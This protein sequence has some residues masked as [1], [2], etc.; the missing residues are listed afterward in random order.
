MAATQ[1]QHQ[2][3]Q[4]F[5][6]SYYTAADLPAIEEQLI[7]VY[8][9]V[10]AAEAAKDSFFSVERFTDRLH[11]HVSGS[12]WGCALG[13]AEGAPIGYA[14]GFARNSSYQW[15]GLITPV[16]ADLI[17]ENDTRTFALCEVMVR[18]NWRGTGTAHTLH[19][20]LLSH[21][22]EERSHLL[23]E[24]EHPRVRALYERWGYNAMGVMQPYD[25]GPR[26]TSMLR[27]I[28]L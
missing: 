5:T 16:P 28:V 10:Y 26:Y 11:R 19:E 13:T 23:V 20:E 8:A 3:P 4:T 21:R 24:E 14:Y 18:Q 6:V 9:E 12:R 15:G 25:D 1:P 2:Q 27:P 7:E 17:A 22:P